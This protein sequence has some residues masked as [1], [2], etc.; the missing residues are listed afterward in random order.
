LATGGRSETGS[1][2]ELAARLARPIVNERGVMMESELWASR[3]E[4]DVAVLRE[5]AVTSRERLMRCRVTESADVLLL[6]VLAAEAIDVEA[7]VA[8]YREYE[9]RCTHSTAV[10]RAVHALAAARAGMLD[11]AERQLAISIHEA[12]ELCEDECEFSLPRC[13][14]IWMALA[15]GNFS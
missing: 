12:T 6:A 11:E 8:R 15:S 7:I 13:G 1:A 9:P 3:D 10:S 4:I 2:E 14:A 5:S